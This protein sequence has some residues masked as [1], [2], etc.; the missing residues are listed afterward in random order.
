MNSV[1][2]TPTVGQPVHRVECNNLAAHRE[3]HGVIVSRF[4]SFH[5]LADAHFGADNRSRPDFD[6][7]IQLGARVDDS[8]WMDASGYG[9]DS[10]TS[11]A[12]SSAAATSSPSTRASACI[13]HSGR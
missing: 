13:F 8:A 5:P 9:V 12:E 7:G 6:A 10:S 2:V 4:N 1:E 11:I 3:R